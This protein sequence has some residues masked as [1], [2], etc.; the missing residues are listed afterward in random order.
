MVIKCDSIFD[1]IGIRKWC[2][3]CDVSDD[4]IP[5]HARIGTFDMFSVFPCMRFILN[6]CLRLK[7]E[8]IRPPDDRFFAHDWVN[9]AIGAVQRLRAIRIEMS[10][11]WQLVSSAVNSD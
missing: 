9:T 1:E 6:S 3:P 5:G 2:E 10:H 7:P 8:K 4:V 11:L